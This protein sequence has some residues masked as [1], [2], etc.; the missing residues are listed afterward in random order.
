MSVLSLSNLDILN[1]LHDQ[2]MLQKNI[3]TKIFFEIT[4]TVAIEGYNA[5]QNFIDQMRHY[6]C[7]FSIDDFGSGHASYTHLKNLSTNELKIDGFFVKDIAQSNQDYAM[8]KSMNEI[9]HSLG[10]H[11][12]AEHVDSIEAIKC[13]RDIGVDYA[14]GYYLHEPMPLDSLSHS[15]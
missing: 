8:V 13:L 5:A 4:E 15:V 14:Q 10:M 11:T 1:F 3:A 6:G 9:A 12:V 7:R 2:F